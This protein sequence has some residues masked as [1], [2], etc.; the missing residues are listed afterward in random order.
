MV[1]TL[2]TLKEV[3]TSS[4][5]FK[6]LSIFLTTKETDDSNMVACVLKKEV[7]LLKKA[8][9]IHIL[10]SFVFTHFSKVTSTP[11][12]RFTISSKPNHVFSFKK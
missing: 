11:S 8:L 3:V 6:I 5:P 1:S 2:F 12:L 10:S 4:C 9:S 7:V